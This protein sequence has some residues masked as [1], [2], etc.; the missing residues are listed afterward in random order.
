MTAQSLSGMLAQVATDNKD[1]PAAVA[2]NNQGTNDASQGLLTA[3]A[4]V[5]INSRDVGT[6]MTK[7]EKNGR[8]GA[9]TFVS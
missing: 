9:R 7:R 3:E 8:R 1:L 5:K 6:S 4:L 2:A